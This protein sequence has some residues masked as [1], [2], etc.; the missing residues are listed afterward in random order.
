MMLMFEQNASHPLA[1]FW[2][3]HG[4]NEQADFGQGDEKKKLETDWLLTAGN[5][6]DLL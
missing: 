5:L 3:Q 4:S 1:F 6:E 2:I